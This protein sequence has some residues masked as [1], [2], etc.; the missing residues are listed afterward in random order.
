MYQKTMAG[1]FA[2][3]MFFLYLCPNALPA[4]EVD[5]DG[6][7]KL[8]GNIAADISSQVSVREI[9]SIGVSDITLYDPFDKKNTLFTGVWMD[10]FAA[11][12]GES[13]V[14]QITFKAID[15]YEFSFRQADWSETKALIATR[16]GKDYIGFDRKGPIRVVF[17]VYDPKKSKESLPKWIW[18]I[19]EVNFR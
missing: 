13:D 7:I 1:F 12:F 8:T 5:G 10:Q 19:T 18:M 11:H 17:P 3:S 15:G 14:T 2:V 16:A 9:E 4:A 6:T